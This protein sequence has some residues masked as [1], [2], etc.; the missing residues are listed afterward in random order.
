VSSIEAIPAVRTAL[1]YAWYRI[2]KHPLMSSDGIGADTRPPTP[3]APEELAR[4]LLAYEAGEET[5]S[6]EIAA[7]GERVYL[8][9]RGR[10]AVLL[11]STGFD[12]LWA[13]AMHLAQRESHP[14]GDSVAEEALR[15]RVYGL[16]AVVR[17]RDSAGVHHNLVVAL[18]S[19][20]T[21]LFTFIG[22]ELGFYFIRQIWPDLSPDAAES[23]T[24]GDTN[25]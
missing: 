8:R 18:T 3:P 17:G 19:F 10:L 13:R 9:L 16:P 2:R 22:E 6:E 24:E 4:S 21:L 1:S 14:A 7:A 11:G 20:I 12:A 15:M 5:G 23:H 25:A